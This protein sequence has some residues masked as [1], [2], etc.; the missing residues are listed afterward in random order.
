FV[1]PGSFAGNMALV[2]LLAFSVLVSRTYR[3]VERL[4][5]AVAFAVMGA[6]IAV[7]GSRGPVAMLIL[8]GLLALMFSPGVWRKLTVFFKGFVVVAVAIGAIVFLIGPVVSERFATIFDPQ[9]FFWK[10]FGPFSYGI[11]LAKQHP[12]GMGMGFTAGVPKF[13][14]S[15]VIQGLATEN[16]D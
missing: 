12:F 6:G 1:M 11:S 15:P 16:I 7:S 13:I 10:W 2:M 4:I 5:V 14:S 9:A 8:A 3:P